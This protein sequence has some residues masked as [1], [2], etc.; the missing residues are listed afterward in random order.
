LHL[1]YRPPYD[2][3]QLLAFL[4]RRAI[5]GVERIEANRY[6]RTVRTTSGTA[7][8]EVAPALAADALEVRISGGEPS[9]LLPLC[10]QVRRMFDLD[11]DPARICAVLGRDP[12]LRAHIAGY[13]GLRIAGTWDVLESGVRAIVGQRISVAAG[14]AILGRLIERV[15]ERC[16]PDGAGLDRLFP[17]AAALA[18]AD[19]EGLGLPRARAAALRNFAGTLNNGAISLD[20]SGSALA[21]GLAQISGVGEWTAGYI[22][23][24]GVGDPDAFPSGDLLL[25]RQAASGAAALNNK[26]LEARAEMWRPFRGYAVFHLWRAA[27]R[28]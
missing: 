25:R 14:R 11:A 20:T 24:R 17:T 7:V 19:L 22:G 21:Q 8:V 5:T 13:P 4:A 28:A 2:W 12:L 27:T 1:A 15:G 10:S 3:P 23:L 26:A 9:D 18:A 16:G 6:A